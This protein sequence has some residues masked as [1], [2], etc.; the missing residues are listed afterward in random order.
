MA[1]ER[2]RLAAQAHEVPARGARL[3]VA[4]HAPRATE[5]AR[6]AHASRLRLDTAR[7]RYKSIGRGLRDSDGR[8]PIERA[9]SGAPRCAGGCARRALRCRAAHAAGRRARRRAAERLRR[10][11]RARSRSAT[12]ASLAGLFYD[13]VDE[14][15]AR[16]PGDQGRRYR[17]PAPGRL[18]ATPAARAEPPTV[19]DAGGGTATLHIDLR[20]RPAPARERG[21]SPTRDGARRSRRPLRASRTSPPRPT[22]TPRR[23]ARRPLRRRQRRHGNGVIS[24]ARAALRRRARRAGGLV[25][26]LQEITPWSASRRATSSSSSTTSR[27]AGSTTRSTRRRPDNGVGVQWQLDNIAPGETREIDVRWLLAAPAPPG[28]VRRPRPTRD[29]SHSQGR[30]CC[31][32]RSPGKT[33]NVKRP[34]RHV[35]LQAAAARRSSSSSTDA[36][37]V[38]VGRDLRHAQGP[39]H[40]DLGRGPQGRHVQ[41]AWFYSGIFKVDADLGAKPITE[42]A[43]AEREAELPEG[44]Q[45]QPRPRPR[46]R[47]RASCGATARASSAPRGQFSSATVRGTQVGRHRPLRRHADAGRPRRRRRARL[48]ASARTSSS[49][50]ASSTSRARRSELGLRLRRLPRRPHGG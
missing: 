29:A 3:D 50:P 48:R 11:P 7:A 42:L 16:R 27:A 32:R 19:V 45:G 38:P 39:R 9:T 5:R 37:Q 43:L 8:H 21:R 20:R 6:P 41:S 36:V 4:A 2:R 26:G 46:S 25:Y 44:E 15:R 17:L 33:V 24:A 23:R 47:R 34:Q 28:T 22:S 14:P 10:R 49:G 18:R 1:R 35:S 40:A 12:T 13:P 30:A 31:R